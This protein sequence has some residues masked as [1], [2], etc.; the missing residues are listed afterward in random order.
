MTTA[1]P[2]SSAET[3]LLAQAVG[4]AMGKQVILERRVDPGLLGGVSVAVGGVLL[5]GSVRAQ[6]K[7]VKEQLKAAKV[8]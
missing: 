2:I 3:A 7:R 1:H 6:L 8:A 4:K 5:D